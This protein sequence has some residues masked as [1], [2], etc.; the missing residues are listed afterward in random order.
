MDELPR[1]TSDKITVT[2][3]KPKLKGFT[4]AKN[5]KIKNFVVDEIGMN[6]DYHIKWRMNLK[7]G[8]EITLPFEYTIEYPIHEE[9][10]DFV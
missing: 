7:P 8:Q 5:V 4:P 6:A 10:T 3:L 1:S 2:L 9:I